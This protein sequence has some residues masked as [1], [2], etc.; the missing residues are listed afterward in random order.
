MALVTV[1]EILA[2]C[3]AEGWAV[4][5]FDIL[6]METVQAVFTGAAAEKS[7][8]I[9]MVYPN[10]SPPSDWPDLVALVEQEAGRTGLPVC[11]QLDHGSSF[12]QAVAALDAG[13]SSVM[14]DASKLP[15]EENIALSRRV[16]E[17]AHDRGAAVEAEL[18]HVGQGTEVLSEVE[19]AGRLT[20]VEEAERFVEE[21]GVDALAVA[22]GTVHGLYR[23]DPDLDFE[24]LEG[25]VDAVSL[26]LVLHGGSGTPDAEMRRAVAGGICK[27]NIWTEVAHAFTAAL[28]R[29]L[30]RPVAECHL[31]GALAS[32]RDAA[33]EVVRDKIALLGAA[34][35]AST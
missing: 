32:A 14:I 15:F 29:E 22:I 27:V 24:R 5:A 7:P 17:E 35:R 21:T 26:P 11:L 16:V 10:H 19:W 3:R 2:G 8:V 12:E 31:P 13:F 20:Q 1:R 23:G 34:G 28:K 4:P 9:V 33:V 18:G 30:Q 25:L 6:N